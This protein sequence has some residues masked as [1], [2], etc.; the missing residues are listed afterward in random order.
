MFFTNLNLWTMKKQ[1]SL[2]LI[3]VLIA[4]LF[5]SCNQFDKKVEIGLLMSDLERERWQ[6]DTTFFVK[7]A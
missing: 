6:R 3:S 7:N 2:G 1:I 4:L 5:S